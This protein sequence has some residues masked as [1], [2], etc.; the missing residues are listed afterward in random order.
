MV[1]LR[2]GLTKYGQN[3]LEENYQQAP[4]YP[5]LILFRKDSNCNVP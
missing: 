4:Q 2:L 5:D 3:V 1:V